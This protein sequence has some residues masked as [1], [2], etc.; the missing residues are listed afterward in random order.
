VDD[1]VAVARALERA[2]AALASACVGAGRRLAL[3]AAELR[4]AGGCAAF[5]G[6]PSPLTHAIG[7]GFEGPVDGSSLDA[8]ERFY[9][10]RGARCEIDV[11]PLADA[12]LV[13]SLS[14]RGYR[15]L[16]LETVLTRTLAD[17][18][19]TTPDA[20]GLRLRWAAP[21]EG[22]AWASLVARG[23]GA[24]APGEDDLAVGRILFESTGALVGECEGAPAA[25]AALAV[26][27]SVGVFLADA[28][29]PAYRGR[30]LQGAAIVERLYAA[31]AEG[32]ARAVA[33]TE[34]GS[35]SER[36]YLRAGFAV[37]YTRVQLVRDPPPLG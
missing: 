15:L 19:P 11:S 16:G 3:P 31:R 28:T 6:A 25:A 17:A 23:F 26:Q 14:E 21:G 4:V 33:F 20:P 8:V 27:D 29:L 1:A 30:G 37:A 7:F 13:S 5:L 35:A 32:C 24:D 2:D 36:H 9:A 18:L 12:S 22:S 34:P 10:S